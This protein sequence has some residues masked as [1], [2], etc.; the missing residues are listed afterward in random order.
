AD[1]DGDLAHPGQDAGTRGVQRLGAGGA[2]GVGGGHPGAVPA[3][4]LREGGAG[5]V[6]GV[7]RAHRLPADDQVHVLPVDAGVGQRGP[8]GD[9]AVFDEGLAPLAP[10]VHADTGDRDIVAH[11]LLPSESAVTGFQRQMVRSPVSSV[12]R[13]STTSSTSAPT[14][15]SSTP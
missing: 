10:R 15:R 2:R 6:A 4:R 13:V 5:D 3:E 9:D 12:Y 1:D 7:A 11:A 14:V 8:R